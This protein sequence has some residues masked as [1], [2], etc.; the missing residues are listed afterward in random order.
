VSDGLAPGLDG[1]AI[2]VSSRIARTCSDSDSGRLS[3]S[4]TSSANISS[5]PSRTSYV[6]SRGAGA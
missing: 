1:G 2:C 3:T 5:T 6:G 4:W